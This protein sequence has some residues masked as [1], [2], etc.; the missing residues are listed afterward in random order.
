VTDTSSSGPLCVYWR[1]PEG[2]MSPMGGL[3]F[4]PVAV[5]DKLSSTRHTIAHPNPYGRSA[6]SSPSSTL[7]ARAN[8]VP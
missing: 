7:N 2:R 5:L 3:G 1:K 6:T 8:Q 4:T